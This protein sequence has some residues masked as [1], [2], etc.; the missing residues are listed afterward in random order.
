[1]SDH[2]VIIIGSGL[3]GLIRGALLAQMEGRK[4]LVLERNADIGGKIMS[5]GYLH[6]PDIT[7]EEYKT[8]LASAV[9]LRSRTSHRTD[10]PSG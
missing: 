10:A 5:Y 6:N 1:M 2:D 9:G 4:V 7:E 3:G 8:S